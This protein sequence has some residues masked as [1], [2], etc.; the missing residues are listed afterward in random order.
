MYWLLGAFIGLGV[1]FLTRPTLLGF[2]IPLEIFASR[3]P[4]DQPFKTQLGIHLLIA[5]AVGALII[6]LLAHLLRSYKPR[7]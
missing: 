2:P 4:L 7:A 6:G 1:G 5:T 3:A